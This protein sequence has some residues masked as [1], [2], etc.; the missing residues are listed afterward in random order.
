VLHIRVNRTPTHDTRDHVRLALDCLTSH[1]RS[2][3]SSLYLFDDDT[4][5]WPRSAEYD[6]VQPECKLIDHG[7]IMGMLNTRFIASQMKDG[8]G[9]EGSRERNEP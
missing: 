1:E 9:K 7:R 2:F 5:R 4:S 6:T 8:C 3:L